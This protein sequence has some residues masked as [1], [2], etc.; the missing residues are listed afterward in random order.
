MKKVATF[1]LLLLTSPTQRERYIDDIQ[2]PELHRL[3]SNTEEFQKKIFTVLKRV[4]RLIS[5]IHKSQVLTSFVRREANRKQFN[6]APNSNANVDQNEK[7]NE[8]VKDFHVRW[9]STYLMLTRLIA[10]RQII[11]EMTYSPQTCIRS[12]IK[13]IKKL[14]SLAIIH[15]DRELLEALAN[16][17]GPFYLATL[18]LSGRQYPT[19]SLSYWIEQNLRVYLSTDSPDNPLENSLRHVILPQLRLYFDSK[20]TPEQKD[21]KLVSRNFSNQVQIYQ[22][23]SSRLSL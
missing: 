12:T 9:S 8:S 2:H 16:I 11:N 13:Q 22:L 19:L 6:L 18:C 5:M 10:A 1:L 4:R 20:V 23:D 17:L 14:K 3:I 7:I 21:A 15:L